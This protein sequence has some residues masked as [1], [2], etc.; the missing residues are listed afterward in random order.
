MHKAIGV[1]EYDSKK[2]EFDVMWL[3]CSGG[4]V[5]VV[6]H[7]ELKQS[8]LVRARNMEHLKELFPN[9]DHFSLENSDYP[10]RAV[11]PRIEVAGVLLKQLE[12]LDYDNFKK[13]IDEIKY[14]DA[15]NFVWKLCLTM[16]ENLGC[17]IMK[18]PLSGKRGQ[19]THPI[20]VDWF[21]H[22]HS[23]VRLGSPLSSKRQPMSWSGGWNRDLETDIGDIAKMGTYTVISLI[24]EEEMKD[25]HV[26]N[27]GEVVTK[28]K[29]IGFICRLGY[30]GAIR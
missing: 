20:K 26:S 4:F 30:Y 10:H 19:V 24:D 6:A 22:P 14:S 29:W 21:S 25:L 11:V 16:V 23:Q 13:S 3:F 27:L 12:L 7:R 1:M 17:E 8:L 5:S 9:A 15:C 28:L 18:W 2:K